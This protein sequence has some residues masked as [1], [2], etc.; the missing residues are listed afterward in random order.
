M[1][2]SSVANAVLTQFDKQRARGTQGFGV[3]DV[4]HNKIFRAAKEDE[5]LEYLVNHDTSH[6]L[7][8][9]RFPTSTINV[10]QAAHPIRT[11]RYFGDTEYVL[12]HNGIIR[13]PNELFVKHS[14]LGIQYHTMLKDLTFNDSESLLWDFA[15]TMQ[16]KQEEMQTRG[17]MAFIC[18]EMYKGKLKKMHFGRNGRSLMVFKD[19]TT[20]ELSSEGRGILVPMN[21]LNTYDFK[22]K[23]LTMKKMVFDKGYQ[24]QGSPYYSTTKGTDHGYASR[25]TEYYP[26]ENTRGEYKS[27][28]EYHL[29]KYGSETRK[30]FVER[31]WNSLRAKAQSQL[32]RLSPGSVSVGDI[33]DAVESEG[34]FIVDNNPIDVDK[35][36]ADK[37]LY[38]PTS[39]QIQN[40]AMEY[41]MEN[42]GNFEQAYTNMEFDYAEQMDES[43]GME[44]L[45]DIRQQLLYESAMEFINSDPEYVDE[46]SVSSIYEALW[47]QQSLALEAGSRLATA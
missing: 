6:L 20:I 41:I 29:H 17:D 4:A 33:L 34:K 22:S 9:H 45:D 16:G 21:M 8:H 1:D 12:V 35:A 37:K 43:V 25:R 11:K 18:M 5:I 30:D 28:D 2:G 10:A 31:K 36:L 7:F 19:K 42:Q 44:T 39:G 27:Y 38:M 32:K 13:N 26:P 3:F 15:L 40:L 46:N 14:E 23:M 24:F 47:S